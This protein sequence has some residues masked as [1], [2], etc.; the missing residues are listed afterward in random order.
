[1]TRLFSKQSNYA[2]ATSCYISRNLLFIDTVSQLKGGLKGMGEL[3]DGV[4]N[5]TGKDGFEWLTGKYVLPVFYRF[6]GT[7]FPSLARE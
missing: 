2:C 4:F 6:T 7:E 5:V 3:N 1:M